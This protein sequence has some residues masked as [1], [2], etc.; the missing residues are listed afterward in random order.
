M[1]SIQCLA[2]IS[3][4]VATGFDNS[5]ASA[6]TSLVAIQPSHG[7]NMATTM[8]WTFSCLCL[9]SNDGVRLDTFWQPHQM[10][11]SHC[12]AKHDPMVLMAPLLANSGLITYSGGWSQITQRCGQGHASIFFILKPSTATQTLAVI[13][14]AW[15]YPRRPR[16]LI[17]LHAALLRC[18]LIDAKLPSAPSWCQPSEG[19]TFSMGWHQPS[20]CSPSWYQPS[21]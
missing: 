10:Y 14:C 6:F 13:L 18:F 17:N 4:Q 1:L 21:E 3:S 2:Y 7:C 9:T 8:P 5:P 19:Y 16:K 11:V 15:R 20:E 12:H